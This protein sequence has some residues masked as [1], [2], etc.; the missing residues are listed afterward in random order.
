MLIPSL[1]ELENLMLIHKHKVQKMG[2]I[3][4]TRSD[5]S[6]VTSYF[7][8]IAKDYDSDL[9]NPYW[10]FGHEILRYLIFRCMNEHF[11]EGQKV[12]L[13]EAGAGTGIWSQHI[14]SMNEGITGKM[15]DMNPHMLRKAHEKIRTI[16]GNDVEIVEGNLEDIHTFPHQ[17]PNLIICFHGPIGFARESGT[18]LKN[19]YSHLE[20]GGLALITTPN[21]MH[22]FNFVLKTIGSIYEMARVVIDGTV[23]F[24]KDM[25]EIF[26]YSP[27]E[28]KDLLLA[29]GFDDVTVLGYPVTVYPSSKDTNPLQSE[30]SAEELCNP[31]KRTALLVVEKILCLKP[32][33]A[34]RGGANLFAICK[35]THSGS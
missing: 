5:Y 1:F 25:P 3:N 10:S 33:N 13:F 12:R 20:P 32:E 29:S 19:L 35:K 15:F 16:S 28:L 27:F 26:C 24:K 22:A 18:V 31:T 8:D 9:D 11:Q 6:Q 14:L 21:K 7:D 2:V 17:K 34:Y 4:F 30:T 23:K